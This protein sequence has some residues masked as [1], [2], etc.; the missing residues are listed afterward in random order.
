MTVF[1]YIERDMTVEVKTVLQTKTLCWIS[2]WTY[3][4]EIRTCSLYLTQRFW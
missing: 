3:V 1:R 2:G 4:E